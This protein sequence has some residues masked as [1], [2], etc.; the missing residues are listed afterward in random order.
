MTV[1]AFTSFE[2]AARQVISGRVEN[3]DFKLRELPYFIAQAKHAGINLPLTEALDAFA[4]RGE[5]RTTDPL[6][7]PTP[8]FW[9]ELHNQTRP[10]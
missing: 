1:C 2:N 5:N 6:G 3:Q 7:I 10:E 4:S 9:Y 8:S